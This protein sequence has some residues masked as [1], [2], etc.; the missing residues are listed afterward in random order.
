MKALLLRLVRVVL[1]K[2]Y[3]FHKPS[4]ERDYASRDRFESENQKTKQEIRI[5][6]ELVA[7]MGREI[8]RNA[9]KK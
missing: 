4:L 5:L 8:A 3:L 2:V 7:R 6:K 9:G 1:A